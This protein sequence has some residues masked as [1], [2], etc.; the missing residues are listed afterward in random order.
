M[1]MSWIIR[2]T[3]SA[4][5][6]AMFVQPA[7][8]AQ[9]SA[10]ATYTP[11]QLGPNS[12][13]YS[14]TLNNTGSTNVSTLWFGW[15]VYP[16]IYDLL[17]NLPT[18]VSAPAGWTGTGLNDSFYGGYSVEWTT[19]SSPLP[20]HSSLSGFSFD[21]P[22]APTVMLQNSPVFGLFRTDTSWAYIGASQGDPGFQFRP[23]QNVPEPV[24]AIALLLPLVV[25]LRRR[26]RV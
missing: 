17:P 10:S 22:D 12:W 21:S 2:L 9:I 20:A 26:R 8:R 1:R 15:V 23:V 3:L 13:R 14:L 4:L 19:T 25:T 7:A 5:V 24:S 11:Q 18:N 16:P 6:I